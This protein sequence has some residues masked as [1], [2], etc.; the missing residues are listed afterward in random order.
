MITAFLKHEARVRAAAKSQKAKIR[1]VVIEKK[2]E[3]EALPTPQ[4]SKLC[5]SSGMKGLRSKEEKVQR[6]LVQWQENDGVDKALAE[7]ALR[8][9]KQELDA[10][11]DTKLQKLCNKIGVDPFVSGVV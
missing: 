5:E 6:L 4:L 8:E 2:Q 3:L 11:D 1:A 7:I 9:R 10:L